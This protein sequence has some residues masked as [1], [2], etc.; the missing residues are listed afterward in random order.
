MA[1][2]RSKQVIDGEI[3]THRL[4]AFGLGQQACRSDNDLQFFSL[5]TAARNPG[6]RSAE[7]RQTCRT[8]MLFEDAHHSNI[9]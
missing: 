1:A 5:T 7:A 3:Q 2:Y 8:L 4:S 6:D 9:R